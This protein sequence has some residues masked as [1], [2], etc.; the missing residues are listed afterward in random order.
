MTRLI[1]LGGF[2]AVLGG[3][4]LV[5][6]DAAGALTGTSGTG[7]H[8]TTIEMVWSA[9]FLIGKLLVVPALLG[10]YLRQS[11]Q[12]GAFGLAAFCAALLGTS[13]MVGSDWSE[14]FIAP[15]LKQAAPAVVDQPPALLAAG[16][17]VN[18]ALETLGWLLFG[19]ATLRARVLP[20]GAAALLIAGTLLPLVGPGWSFV[21]W[22]AAIVWMGL[23]VLRERPQAL[24]REL[25]PASS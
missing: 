17:L 24:S 22:N 13:L 9:L 18:F 11:E 1:R 16:F 6:P 7:Y 14:M 10:I 3:A 5:I 8:G 12:A 20:R 2:A 21:V 19:I 25:A 23:A 4:L 15:I